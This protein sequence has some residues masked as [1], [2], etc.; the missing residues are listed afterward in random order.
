MLKYCKNVD[1]VK[2]MYVTDD[3]HFNIIVT[4]ENF[5]GFTFETQKCEAIPAGEKKTMS[6][7]RTYFRNT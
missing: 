4:V 2:T 3:L 6:H 7:A 5:H 1:G